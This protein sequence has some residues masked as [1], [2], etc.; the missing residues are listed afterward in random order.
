[1]PRSKLLLILLLLFGWATI[2]TGQT[3]SPQGVPPTPHPTA[4]S[5]EAAFERGL[6]AQQRKHFDA[7]ITE[8]SKG[9]ALAPAQPALW[10]GRS[11]ARFRRSVEVHNAAI[12]EFWK[13]RTKSGAAP[14]AAD[15]WPARE[16]LTNALNDADRAV[17]L[18][19]D[20][21]TNSAPWLGVAVYSNLRATALGTRFLCLRMMVSLF[22]PGRSEEAIAAAREYFA[23]E[24][25][26]TRRS[27]ITLS[28]ANLMLEVDRTEL[29]LDLYRQLLG[30]DARNIDAT[31]GEGL[32]LIALGVRAD[33]P[34]LNSR[35]LEAL[36]KFTDAAPEDH[37]FRDSVLEIVAFAASDIGQA[38]VQ[39]S[40]EGTTTPDMTGKRPLPGA[41][42]NGKAVDLPKPSFPFVAKFARAAGSV[43]VQVMIDEDGHVAKIV[44]AA[45]HP[46][47]KAAAV[48]AAKQAKFTRTTVNGVPQ[49][50]TGTII[51][52]FLKQ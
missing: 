6:E 19:S 10:I 31:L 34:A 43:K 15:L 29:A 8:F 37:P 36:K 30:E 22:D 5:A 48:E 14:P 46:L 49:T 25:V 32:A 52:N 2:T 33:D 11:N 9:I 42:L 50:V 24:T 13:M 23:S 3:G 35:G 20:S 26:E 7:A 4:D 41:I 28:L 17:E 44:S 45:G 21:R 38:K 39:E 47:F 18:T 40:T 1:M 51:Y 16:E 27:F 12:S